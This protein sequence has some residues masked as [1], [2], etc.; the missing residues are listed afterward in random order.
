MPKRLPQG[1]SIVA[2]LNCQDNEWGLFRGIG[3]FAKLGF[4]IFLL[5]VVVVVFVVGFGTL[6]RVFLR[7]LFGLRPDTSRN[8]GGRA[9]SRGDR[10]GDEKEVE[11]VLACSV[12]GVHV[13]ESEGIEAEGKFFCCEAH[14]K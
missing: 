4:F 5:I 14:R 1:G 10:F 8:L 9:S 7:M 2:M 13:P 6:V 12:C 3:V 11:R